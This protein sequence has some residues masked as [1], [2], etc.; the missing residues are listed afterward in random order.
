[1]RKARKFVINTRANGVDSMKKGTIELKT[2]SGE[3]GSFL[4]PNPW[5]SLDGNVL[6]ESKDKL[7]L[8]S[9]RIEK[10]SRFAGEIFE[11]GDGY[12]VD[13]LTDSD[14]DHDVRRKWK[15]K[16]LR[17]L[18]VQLYHLIGSLLGVKTNTRD[19]GP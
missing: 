11:D 1:M 14:N 19:A 7:Y 17:H 6:E 8:V 9:R 15:I 2:A 12:D 10:L 3:A 16:R 18:N 5:S 4:T 13:A